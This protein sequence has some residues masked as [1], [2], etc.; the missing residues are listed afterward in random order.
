MTLTIV[1]LSVILLL[2]VVIV[3]MLV[4][5]WPGRERAEIE[6]AGN[7]LRREMAEHRAESIQLLHAIRIEVEDSVKESIERELA[8]HGSRGGRS[9][10]SR[11]AAV[12]RASSKL[13]SPASPA[14]T[15]PESAPAMTE[16]ER[17]DYGGPEMILE[18]RQL[19]L[20]PESPEPAGV[21]APVVVAAGQTPPVPHTPKDPEPEPEMISMGYIDDIPDVE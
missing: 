12:P 4:T 6:R 5:G 16:E 11:V 7:A 15:G 10:A 14:V 19:P 1:L 17:A 3:A 9:R 18:E 2:L 21:S 8:G 20:F 13:R